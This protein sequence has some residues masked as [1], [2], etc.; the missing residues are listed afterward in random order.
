MKRALT[1]RKKSIL[2]NGGSGIIYIIFGCIQFFQNDRIGD[3]VL[4]I[5]IA[6]P[7]LLELITVFLKTEPEDEMAQ[8]NKYRTKAKVY[9]LISLGI[10]IYI[11]MALFEVGLMINIKIVLPFLLGA[12]KLL[13][14]ILF[15]AYEKVGA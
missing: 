4:L 5:L 3:G 13:E 1:L 15:V 10:S 6:I 12:F 11:F 8:Y 14:L 9:E 2:T 7:T